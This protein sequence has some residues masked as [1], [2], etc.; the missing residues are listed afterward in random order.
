MNTVR[1]PF[2]GYLEMTDE[3]NKPDSYI[4][5]TPLPG[6]KRY[7][8]IFLKKKAFSIL[9]ELQYEALVNV[10]SAGK[11]LDFGG[12]NKSGYL[13]ILTYDSYESVNIDPSMEPTWLLKIGTPLPCPKIHYDTALSLN[14]IEHIFEPHFVLQELFDVLK[15]GGR[16]IC[17]VPFLYAIHAHPDDFFR[18]TSSWW[19]RSLSQA[20]FK[21]IKIQ[22]LLWGP[23]STGIVCSGL[24]GPFKKARTHI[25]LVLDILYAKLRFSRVDTHYSGTIGENLQKYALGFFVQAQK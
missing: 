7:W 4:I 15:P 12:G 16:L 17:T 24:P 19:G 23:F 10:K 22:P 8:N 11:V 5:P 2:N 1:I 20:G 6:L 13:D 21:A 14:T 25:A 18:P 3:I 9:R